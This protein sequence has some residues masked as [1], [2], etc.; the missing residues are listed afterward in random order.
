MGPEVNPAIVLVGPEAAVSVSGPTAAPDPNDAHVYTR[1]EA[2]IALWRIQRKIS[3]AL[4]ELTNDLV[5]VD[6]HSKWEIC[7][8]LAEMGAPAKV[9]VP[10]IAPD[11]KSQNPEARQ[12]AAEALWNIDAAQA[13]GVVDALI[14]PMN[15]LSATTANAYSATQGAELLGKMGAA[16]QS[17]APGLERL[18]KH[19][20]LSARTAAAQAWRR[21]ALAGTGE[22][23]MTK[24][25]RTVAE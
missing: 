12:R 5:R 25:S 6:G 3:E 7:E 22:A 24:K 16:A 8:V 23:E 15:E 9:A 13:P 21:I 10:A 2:D 20:Y 19:P 1:M 4:P 11:L 17:A 18:L 14:E